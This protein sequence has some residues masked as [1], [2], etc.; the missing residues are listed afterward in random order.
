M[1]VINK[2]WVRPRNNQIVVHTTAIK[3]I[4]CFVKKQYSR[5]KIEHITFNFTPKFIVITNNPQTQLM[6]YDCFGL[7]FTGASLIINEGVRSQG[8][9]V[10]A[11]VANNTLSWYSEYD[12]EYQLNKTIEYFYICFM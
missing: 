3:A 8:Y 5:H 6:A 7:W 11:T 9:E 2:T 10:K 12:S 1:F 4:N